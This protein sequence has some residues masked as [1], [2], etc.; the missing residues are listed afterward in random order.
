MVG[1]LDQQNTAIN[2]FIAGLETGGAE[3]VC[4]TLCNHLVETGIPVRLVLLRENGRFRTLISPLV[5]IHCFK[6]ERIR[7]SFAAVRSF[8]KNTDRPT[9]VF[10]VDLAL[11]VAF[12]RRK[13]RVRRVYR[14]GSF[15]LRH[16]WKG[17]FIYGLVGRRFDLVIA[18][19]QT[20]ADQL[21]QLGIPV[22]KIRQIPN[23]LSPAASELSASTR[24]KVDPS[25]AH[26][27]TVGRLDPVKNFDLLLAS[28]AQFHRKFPGAK[29]TIFGEG[30]DRPRLESLIG[31]LGIGECTR[32][33][34]ENRNLGEIFATADIFVS[35]SKFEGMPNSL[36][37]AI[38]SGCRVFVGVGEGGTSEYLREVGLADRAV[39][40]RDFQIVFVTAAARIL[41]GDSGPEVAAAQRIRRGQDPAAVSKAIEAVLLGP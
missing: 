7:K 13:H 6:T 37:E 20:V 28:F 38:L 33:A 10:G 27:V 14:E 4:V 19:T 9:L 21:K 12:C 36:I 5:E 25:M 17:R 39:P 18:Q 35:C 11:V 2:L 22:N 40:L 34:G 30:R 8:F 3:R 24:T 23:P 26:F 29:L 16:G 32:L 31:A 15:P 1:N 41:D